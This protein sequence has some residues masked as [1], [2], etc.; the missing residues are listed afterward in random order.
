MLNYSFKFSDVSIDFLWENKDCS[1][2]SRPLSRRVLD[3]ALSQA[4]A[5]VMPALLATNTQLARQAAWCAVFRPSQ[6]LVFSESYRAP[7]CSTASCRIPVG[8]PAAPLQLPQLLA[9]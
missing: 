8:A 6:L 1:L 9:C 3:A 7:L 2:F 5:Q 4:P